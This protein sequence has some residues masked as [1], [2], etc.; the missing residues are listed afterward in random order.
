MKKEKNIL[1]QELLDSIEQNSGVLDD[2]VKE[3]TSRYDAELMEY[4]VYV[5]GVLREDIPPT[6]EELDDFTMMQFL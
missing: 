3:L 2:A 5:R 4:V 1:S 6:D